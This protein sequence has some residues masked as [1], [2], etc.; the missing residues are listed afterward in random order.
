MGKVNNAELHPEAWEF[1]LEQARNIMDTDLKDLGNYRIPK[2]N[3]S[4]D[5]IYAWDVGILWMKFIE[6]WY[7]PQHNSHSVFG[8]IQY[9]VETFK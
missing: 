7:K 2:P 6:E 3:M 5:F 1:Y 9:V 8:Q 4:G